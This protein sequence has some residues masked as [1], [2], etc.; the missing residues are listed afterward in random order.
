MLSKVIL[1]S[2]LYI[3]SIH[4]LKS[5][6]GCTSN[7]EESEYFS[8]ETNNVI[9]TNDQCPIKNQYVDTNSRKPAE[10]IFIPAGAYQMGTDD[11]VIVDDI[12]GPRR[13][14]KLKS[15]YLDKYEVSNRDFDV[16]T[17]STNYKTEAETFGD[18][19]VFTLFLN[20]TFKEKLKDFRVMQAPWWYKVDGT[21]WRHPYG[22]DSDITDLMD[23]PV[24]HVSW[25]DAT[26]YCKWRDARLP[27]EV[28]WE[29][30][31]RGGKQNIT[32]PWGDKLYPNKKHL[33]NIWQGTF[34]NHNSVKDGYIGTNPVHLF[35][36]NDLGLCNI[37]GNVWEWTKDS[38]SEDNIKEKVKKGGS[39][40]CHRSY[41]YRYRCSARSHNTDDSS[42]GN[43]GFRCAKTA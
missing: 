26:A 31:C 41:C 9:L 15:F 36:Q 25:N 21:N 40:L 6:C 11:I 35:P 42:A 30:A 43:L 38:W 32:Y 13:L 3:E 18:S 27:S 2:I 22:P 28:E 1:I 5:G 17:E 29:A 34:P 16:F 10:M 4:N 24:I 20:S 19:F 33:T 23:H 14:V 39:Y 12:E 8:E 37:A 7:R